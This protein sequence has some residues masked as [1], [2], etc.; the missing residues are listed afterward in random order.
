MDVII[1]C[2]LSLVTESV[3]QDEDD[4]EPPQKVARAVSSYED[5]DVK[6]ATATPRSNLTLVSYDSLR[7]TPIHAV[8]EWTNAALQQI[9]SVAILLPSGVGTPDASKVR[10]SEDQHS[11]QVTAKWPPMMSSVDNLHAFWNQKD[12]GTYPGGHPRMVAFH[13]FF[14]FLRERENDDLFSV[15]TIFLGGEQVL[16]NVLSI[17]RMGTDEGERIIFVDLQHVKGLDYKESP[18]GAFSIIK[19]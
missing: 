17:T 5:D 11:L 15:A 1:R 12:P 18:D 4:E 13:Q 9:V 10:V 3:Q 14:S 16:K 19:L 7:F 6:P 8:A 2:F